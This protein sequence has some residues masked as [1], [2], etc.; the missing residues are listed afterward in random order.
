MLKSRKVFDLLKK[1]TQFFSKKNEYYDLLGISK[2]ASKAD[3]KK[4][5]AKKA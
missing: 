1:N 2:D 5:Y 3:I 4:A